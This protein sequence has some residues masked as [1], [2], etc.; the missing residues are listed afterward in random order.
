MAVVQLGDG[1]GDLA[2]V[3]LCKHAVLDHRLA[4]HVGAQRHNRAATVAAEGAR[5]GRTAGRVGVLVCSNA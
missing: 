3:F 1:L 4:C 5:D 2:C